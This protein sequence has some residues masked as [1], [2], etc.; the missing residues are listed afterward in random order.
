M[1]KPVR[2][3]SAIAVMFTLAACNGGIKPEQ[4]EEIL[5]TPS[6]NNEQ[7]MAAVNGKSFSANILSGS[8]PGKYVFKY[9][10]DGTL[11]IQTSRYNSTRQW[12]IKDATLCVETCHQYY[13][14]DATGNLYGKTD[15]KISIVLKPQ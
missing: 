4:Q 2:T 15:G 10:V 14:D 1:I 8:H 11:Y 13:Q 3:F 5:S 7:L 12:S 6:L 9:D